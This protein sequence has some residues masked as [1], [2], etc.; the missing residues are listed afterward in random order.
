MKRMTIFHTV[1]P[2]G[3]YPVGV[4]ME[5]SKIG[6]RAIRTLVWYPAKTVA[7]AEP[8][9]FVNE[10]LGAAVAGSAVL[11]APP[12]R[13]AAPYPLI[14]YSPALTAPADASVFYTQNLASHGYVV[15]SVDHMDANQLD[16]IVRN[17]NWRNLVRFFRRMSKEF[18]KGN[19]SVTV[20]VMFSGHF[21]R[22]E[23][24]LRYRPLEA[25]TAI[26]NAALWNGDPSSPLMGMIDLERIGM[27]GHSLGAWTT[28][29]FGGMSLKYDERL[30]AGRHDINSGCIADHDP[31]CTP[32]ARSLSTPTALRDE[33]V[34]AI[35]PMGSPIF[36]HNIRDN[37]MEI[38][39]P[40][41]FLTGD[42]R[43]WE[44][45]L[46]TQKEVYDNAPGPKHFVI[47]RDTDHYVIC[48]MWMKSRIILNRIR[49]LRFK[50][51]FQ[52]KAQVYKDY[53]VAFFDRYL[54]GDDRAAHILWEPGHPFVKQVSSNI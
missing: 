49:P 32:F 10:R 30:C 17:G 35:L 15:I 53:S 50:R 8:F 34:K 36:Q 26:D 51:D 23:F 6:A 33:R 4:R 48:D 22:T 28:L 11:N 54:K 41:M 52:E 29:L 46:R 45:T 12:D 19:P 37:A 47:I 31:C 44:A 43:R 18:I 25:R 20:L 42:D 21:R 24:G 2:D 1:S 16:L 40:V 7:G 13:S 39:V 9:L 38:R 14:L 27:T 5:W 3:P